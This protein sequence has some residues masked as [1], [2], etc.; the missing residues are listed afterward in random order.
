MLFTIVT[1]RICAFTQSLLTLYVATENLLRDSQ[2]YSGFSISYGA[3]FLRS[4]EYLRMWL[5]VFTLTVQGV[6]TITIAI[7]NLVTLK[8][9]SGK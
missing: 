4:K 1:S 9:D 6:F 8:S 3:E 7:F 2:K 5:N